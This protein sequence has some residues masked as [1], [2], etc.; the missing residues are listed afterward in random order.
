MG[1]EIREE[2]TQLTHEQL[3]TGPGGIYS[4]RGYDVKAEYPEVYPGKIHP[5]QRIIEEIRSI[6]IKLGFQNQR[7]PS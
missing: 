6:F 5:L 4:Y 3:K 7:E 2:A 1:F